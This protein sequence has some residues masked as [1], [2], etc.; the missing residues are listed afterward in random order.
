MLF[1]TFQTRDPVEHKPNNTGDSQRPQQ[2]QSNSKE[3]RQTEGATG[4]QVDGEF[5][6]SRS[7][8]SFHAEGMS[9][10]ISLYW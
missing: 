4:R 10:I 9:E 5:H 3:G 7:Q 1:F 2:T 8:I 6:R